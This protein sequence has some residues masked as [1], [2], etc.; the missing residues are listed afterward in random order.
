MTKSIVRCDWCLSHPISVEYHDKEWGAP[1]HD[2][3][4]LLEFLI[5]DAAQAGLSWLTILKKRQNYRQAFVEYDAAKIARFTS[6]R[7]AKL[8]QD[9]GIV[10][11]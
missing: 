7:I 6:T 1:V 9:P 4:R 8:M 11:N 2:D 5:L 3:R 10:R